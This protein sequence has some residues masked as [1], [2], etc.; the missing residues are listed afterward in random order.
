MGE[1]LKHK[2]AKREGVSALRYEYLNVTLNGKDLGIYAIEEHFE[3]RLI[4]DNNRRE[5]PIV[6][7][8]EDVDIGNL[9]YFGS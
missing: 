2:T 5:G 1:W 8:S 3:K 9:N 4:E 6:S 7:F